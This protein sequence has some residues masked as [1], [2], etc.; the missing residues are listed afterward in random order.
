MRSSYP[1]LFAVAS[2]CQNFLS[3]TRCMDFVGEVPVSPQIPWTQVL[4]GLPRGCFLSEFRFMPPVFWQQIVSACFAETFSGNLGICP[5]KHN[6]RLRTIV[7]R[8]FTSVQS[9]P[10]Q[11]LTLSFEIQLFHFILRMRHWQRMWNDW[12]LLQWVCASVQDP[13]P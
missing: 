5:N 6:L 7:S 8:S 12:S 10:V 9:S 11:S 4:R 1:E 2:V 13:E 3:W